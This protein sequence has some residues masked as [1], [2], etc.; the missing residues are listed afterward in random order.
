ML[1]VSGHAFLNRSSTLQQE[2]FGNVSVLVTASDLDELVA[3]L[4]RL[5]GSLTGSVRSAADGSED[6]M[7]EA[8]VEVLGEKVG[9]LLCGNS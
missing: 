4:K 2:A 3:C 6:Y 5:D 1:G 7:Y 9:R 8:V